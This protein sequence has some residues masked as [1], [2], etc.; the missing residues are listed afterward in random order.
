MGEIPKVDVSAIA[1][2]KA[3]ISG[4]DLKG[5]RAEIHRVERVI[6]KCLSSENTPTLQRLI[7][8]P[9]KICFVPDS[10]NA[11]YQALTQ[12]GFVYML[13]HG[14]HGDHIDDVFKVSKKFF[15]LP[16][17]VK[18]KSFPREES[19]QVRVLFFSIYCTYR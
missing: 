16:Q 17:D 9:K 19:S 10:G 12:Y 4:K 11:L 13:N 3:E 7:F 5:K 1:V 15:D 6:L 8:A 18:E 2:T 14:V